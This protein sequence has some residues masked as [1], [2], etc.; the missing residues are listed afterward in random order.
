MHRWDGKEAT[1][2]AGGHGFES[3]R[4]RTRIYAWKIGVTCDDTRVR[5]SRGF[6]NIFFYFLGSKTFSTGSCYRPVAFWPVLN[7]VSFSTGQPV[8]IGSPVLN[9][10]S[11]PVLIVIFL[12]VN[13]NVYVHLVNL[14]PFILPSYFNTEIRCS[15]FV[16]FHLPIFRW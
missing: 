14:I 16:S 2:E 4:S 3:S 15:I 5:V 12:T 11:R 6:V 8:P 13:L 9:R 10:G 1:S 7:N